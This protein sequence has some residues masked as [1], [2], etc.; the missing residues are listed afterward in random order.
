MR[1]SP[2]GLGLIK[3]FEGFRS[4]AYL[5]S[6]GVPTIGYGHT[7]NVKP[8]DEITEEQALEFLKADVKEHAGV[9]RLMG[10]VELTQ[11]QF[12]ALASLIFNIGTGAF[13]S[14]TLRK[15]LV[16]GMYTLAADEF[17]RW[18]RAGGKVVPGLERRR[19]A[20]RHLFET[21]VYIYR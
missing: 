3:A 2:M 7:L 16:E 15:R 12:D 18:N 19:R 21:G 20:E 10:D 14:S 9:I 5:D 8:G 6:A 11:Y 13:A 4:R 1:V 17:L